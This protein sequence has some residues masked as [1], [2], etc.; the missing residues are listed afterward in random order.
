MSKIV[1]HKIENLITYITG[2]SH[3]VEEKNI[4]L[5]FLTIID[6]LEEIRDGILIENNWNNLRGASIQ[7]DKDPSRE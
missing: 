2:V 1:D 4:R 5:I 3:A 6:S 7:I